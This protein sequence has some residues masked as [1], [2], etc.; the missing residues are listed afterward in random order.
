[1]LRFVK[2][3]EIPSR[4][5]LLC[6][7]H[8]KLLLSLI[9]LLWRG[10]LLDF[11]VSETERGIDVGYPKYALRKCNLELTPGECNGLKLALNLL[12][13]GSNVEHKINVGDVLLASKSQMN[14]MLGLVWYY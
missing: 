7:Q 6:Q 11:Q 10:G 8:H 5:Q 2:W 13:R 1:M 14:D 4:W 12:V 3:I 9:G